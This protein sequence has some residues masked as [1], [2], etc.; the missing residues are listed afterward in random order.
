VV[1]LI[2]E[3]GI[4]KSRL[5]YEFIRG[6]ITPPW[7]ILEAQGTAYG[8]ATAYRPIIDLIDLLKGYFRIEDRDDPLTVCD[9]VTGT[10]RSLDEA[11]TPMLPAVLALLDMPVQDSTWQAIEATQRRQRTLDAVKR[12]LVWES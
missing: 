8:Q 9:K 2:G 1:G 11:L 5:C 6:S 7:R 4:G 12:L 3:P 10:L